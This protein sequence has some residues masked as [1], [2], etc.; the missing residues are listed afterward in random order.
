MLLTEKTV[1]SVSNHLRDSAWPLKYLV[2]S[3]LL[4]QCF[5]LAPIDINLVSLAQSPQLNSLHE[6]PSFLR[7]SRMNESTASRTIEF[8]L[9]SLPASLSSRDALVRYEI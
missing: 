3:S 6:V 2:Y 7:R 8:M 1:Q 9:L 5:V 4:S